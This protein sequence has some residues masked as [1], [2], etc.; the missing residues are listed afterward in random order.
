[1]PQLCGRATPSAKTVAAAAS[2][3]LPPASSTARPTRAAAGDSVAMAPRGPVAAG[4][5]SEPCLARAGVAMARG[6]RVGGGWNSEPC[7]ARAGVA[8]ATAR[9][10][11]SAARVRAM[12][13]VYPP[14]ASAGH[15]TRER[16][17]E[18]LELVGRPALEG[19]AVRLVRR[20]D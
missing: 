3:A 12:G 10:T 14:E 8:M 1:M 19:L 18:V 2:T 15:R 9:T 4:G 17:D 5:N 11:L 6:G 13:G 7:L 20:D 16:L